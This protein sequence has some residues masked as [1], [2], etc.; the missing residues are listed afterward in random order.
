ME[1]LRST[2]E[3]GATRSL[4]WREAQIDGVK[5]IFVQKQFPADS[6]RAVSDA[7]GGKVVQLDPLAEDVVA[8][9]QQIAE[10]IVQA[11]EQ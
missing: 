7:I 9:L 2:Y 4:D 1:R 10:S 8:N 11:L 5:V 6:A 3:S